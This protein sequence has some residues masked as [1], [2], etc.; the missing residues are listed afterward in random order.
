MYTW[1]TLKFK[2]AV[3][4]CA[5]SLKYITDMIEGI[6]PVT[7]FPSKSL[8]LYTA[9]QYGIHPTKKS[10]QLLFMSETAP[11]LPHLLKLLRYSKPAASDMPTTAPPPKDETSDA[12]EPSGQK[13]YGLGYDTQGYSWSQTSSEVS[14]KF[15]LPSG[16]TK[17]EVDCVISPKELVVG[18]IDG[19]TYF[20]GE[21]NSHIDTEGSTWTIEDNTYG[22]NDV[23]L[24]F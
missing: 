16:V 19:T 8:A 6:S 14:I 10:T 15:E 17:K 1:Y 12:D 13:H 22:H 3:D 4:E 21:L 11:L 9:F 7:S 20:R 24:M 2:G 5:L 23:Y 18:L